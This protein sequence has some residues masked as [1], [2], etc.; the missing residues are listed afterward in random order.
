MN[1]KNPQQKSVFKNNP[2]I[3]NGANGELQGETTETVA[4]V[5]SASKFM[6]KRN[7]IL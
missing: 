2:T 4:D 3:L 7:S 1:S 6:G 5:N